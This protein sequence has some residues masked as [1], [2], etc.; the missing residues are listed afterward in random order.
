ME[1]V[2]PIT[3]ATPRPDSVPLSNPAIPNS[4]SAKPRPIV[5]QFDPEIHITVV[6][7]VWKFF[8]IYHD[9]NHVQV[10]RDPP[11][12]KSPVGFV[13]PVA[14]ASTTNVVELF[15]LLKILV[16]VIAYEDNVLKTLTGERSDSAT[17]GLVKKNE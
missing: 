11:I 7:S 12:G 8:I 15:K 13:G 4:G 10:S 2:N 6:G 3:C 1:V 14:V 17:V 9:I 5:E 16:A